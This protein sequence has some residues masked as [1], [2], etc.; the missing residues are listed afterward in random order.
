M[1]EKIRSIYG[2]QN[3][4]RRRGNGRNGKKRESRKE[5]ERSKTRYTFKGIP[6]VLVRVSPA[7]LLKTA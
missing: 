6:P 5:E 1:A 3:G 7:D 4:V 2:G